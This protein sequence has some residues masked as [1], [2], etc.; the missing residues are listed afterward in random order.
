MK[1]KRKYYSPTN[2]HELKRSAGSEAASRF[3]RRLDPS[4]HLLLSYPI[5]ADK[6]ANVVEKAKG[7]EKV[8]PIDSFLAL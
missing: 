3:H 1:Y 6:N 4:L 5:Y 8:W 7:I 2:F